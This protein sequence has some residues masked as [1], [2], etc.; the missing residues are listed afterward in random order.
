MRKNSLL[1]FVCSSALLFI[2]NSQT[3]HADEQDQQDSNVAQQTVQNNTNNAS[4]TNNIKKDN[5][6]SLNTDDLI[7]SKQSPKIDSSDLKSNRVENKGIEEQYNDNSSEEAVNAN[8]LKTEAA[9]NITPQN[10]IGAPVY[11]TLPIKA[12]LDIIDEDTGKVLN[13]YQNYLL[14]ESAI[15][16]NQKNNY[17]SPYSAA[18]VSLD[19]WNAPDEVLEQ[20]KDYEKQG[21]IQ[22]YS[23]YYPFYDASI[24]EKDPNA[25]YTAAILYDKADEDQA[26][27]LDQNDFVI[28]GG[29]IM[30]FPV[31]KQSNG[32]T[33]SIEDLENSKIIRI[34]RL[35]L[36]AK[37]VLSPESLKELGERNNSIIKYS[38]Y[39]QYP[40]LEGT[41]TIKLKHKKEIITD[42]KVIKEIIHYVDENNNSLHEDSTNEVSFTRQGI[43]DIPTGEIKWENYTPKNA[44]FDAV[45][46]PKIDGYFTYFDKVDE[47]T[48][49]PTDDDYVVTVVYKKKQSQTGPALDYN[50]DSMKMGISGPDL[51][52]DLPQYPVSEL[53]KDHNI[54]ISPLEES[55][56]PN[57]I[58]ENNDPNDP[59][60]ENKNT[61][62]NEV[63]NE[64]ST[65]SNKEKS[66]RSVIHSK[67]QEFKVNAVRSTQG[68]E[69]KD[70]VKTSVAEKISSESKNKKISLFVSKENKLP[71]TNETKNNQYSLI[72]ILTTLLSVGL[73]QFNRKKTK[74]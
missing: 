63:S 3:V 61:P 49:L 10:D 11:S 20:V 16:F 64:S 12:N 8:I 9:N 41:F 67:K 1:T 53:R 52:Y 70:T 56:E 66:F 73:I 30:S 45:S 6:N 28:N 22:T 23:D 13:H 40:P 43:K 57:H 31:I 69:I 71:K 39:N 58:P 46:N 47:K 38:D 55:Q 34:F 17:T 59:I 18:D 65:P 36:S 50:L 72:G 74:K 54:P 32:Y 14:S 60:P 5:N 48:V 25:Y 15:T 68:V 35:H 19:N 27:I 7:V 44:T 4:K 29:Q 51:S 21:Y 37:S 26:N 42:S 2:L 62:K 24:K 33:R